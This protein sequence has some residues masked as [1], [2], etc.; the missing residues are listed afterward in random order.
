MAPNKASAKVNPV[1]AVFLGVHVSAN[2]SG[3]SKRNFAGLLYDLRNLSNVVADRIQ[4]TSAD[5]LLPVIL[6]AFACIVA[7]S[8]LEDLAKGR[9]D[10]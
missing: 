3:L 4:Q 7:I 9:S 2:V 5:I 1:E 8:L 6:T 10:G